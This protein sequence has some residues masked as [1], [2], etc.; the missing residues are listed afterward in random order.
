MIGKP[1]EGIAYRAAINNARADAADNGAEIKQRQRVGVRVDHP[2]ERDQDA[3][4]ENHHAWTELVDQI[5]FEGDEPRLGQYEQGKCELNR[6]PSPMVLL[7][8]RI[9]E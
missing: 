4:E 7:V 1:F 9:D 6:R 8:H 3:A 5:A 2:R